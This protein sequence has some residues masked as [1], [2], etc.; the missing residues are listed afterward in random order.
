MQIA[1][2]VVLVTGGSSGIGKGIAESLVR[3][4][5]KVA[6]TGRDGARL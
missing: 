6:I 1:D 5:A 2:S 3:A 4:G